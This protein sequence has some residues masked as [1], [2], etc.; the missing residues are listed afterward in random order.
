[1]EGFFVFGYVAVDFPEVTLVL[2]QSQQDGYGITSF[3]FQ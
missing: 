1:L 2:F 3:V